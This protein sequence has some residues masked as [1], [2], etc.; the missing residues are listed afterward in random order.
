M[1]KKKMAHRVRKE[2]RFDIRCPVTVRLSNGANHETEVQGV[3]CDISVG[4]ARLELEEP[5]VCGTRIILF[6]H[7]RA[8]DKQV[9]TVRFEGIV[10]RLKEQPRFEVAMGF[11]GSGRFLQKQLGDLQA[12]KVAQTAQ[13]G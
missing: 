7:F 3:L 2:R 1:N 5:I 11:R 4:G 13:A 10:E 12:T 6:V 9:T 8:P